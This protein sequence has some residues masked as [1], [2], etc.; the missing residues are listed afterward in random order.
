MNAESSAGSPTADPAQQEI[1]RDPWPILP[2][3]RRQLFAIL[4]RVVVLRTRKS[5]RA[6]AGGPAGSRRHRRARGAPRCHAGAAA[7]PDRCRK[8]QELRRADRAG[9]ENHLAARVGAR[10]SVSPCQNSRP[11]R[12]LAIE[13]TRLTCAWVDNTGGWGGASAGM[14]EGRRGR[15]RATAPLSSPESRPSPH[16]RR[17]EVR[18]LGNADLF[19]AAARKASRISQRTRVPRPA[20][21]RRT[22]ACSSP[23]WQSPRDA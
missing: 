23:P 6:P 2:N 9:R 8:L 10:A 12:A 20:V 19:G 13:A 1:V 22:R 5:R 14:Q 3:R 17:V 18:G 7:P 21:R 4:F 15:R 11:D 16:S